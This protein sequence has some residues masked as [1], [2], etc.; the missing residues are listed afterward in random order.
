MTIDVLPPETT[1]APPAPI[2]VVLKSRAGLKE[3]SRI[4]HRM[5]QR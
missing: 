1:A 3:Y 4:L 2:T 5:V